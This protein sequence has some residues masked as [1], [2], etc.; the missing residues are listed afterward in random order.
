[1]PRQPFRLRRGLLY[2][3]GSALGGI[4][5]PGPALFVAALGS[6]VT[7]SCIAA[8]MWSAAVGVTGLVI[9]SCQ[10]EQSRAAIPV[11]APDGAGA[12]EGDPPA[13]G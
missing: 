1:M 6:G 5:L 4:A 3:A 8:F 11:P 13:A 2:G 9:G 10:P 12:E 7:E